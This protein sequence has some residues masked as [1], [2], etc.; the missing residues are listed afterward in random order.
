MAHGRSA[1]RGGGDPWRGGRR[2][3][4]PAFAAIDLGTNNCRL[5]IAEPAREGF[6]VVS[7]YS[8]IVR[9]GEGLAATGRLSDAAMER[10]MAALCACAERL[11]ARPV[12]ASRCMATQA[13]R[14]A[15]N[16]L[17]FLARVERELGL[18]FAIIE[19]EEEARL[20]VL[21]CASL[22][23]PAVEAAL[24]VDI[25]GGSTELSWVEPS[26]AG[27]TMIR[28]WASL[29]IGVV[30]LAERW[31]EPTPDAADGV[32]RPGWFDSMKRDAADAMDTAFADAAALAHLMRMRKAHIIGTS[33]AVTSLAGVH[34]ELER[35][36]R[37]LIDGVWLGANECAAATRR[38]F[39][40]ALGDRA[41]HPCIGPARADLVLAGCA[42]LEAVLDRWPSDRVRVADRGLREGALIT[43][44]AA[45]QAGRA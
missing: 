16:G 37:S 15:A 32:Q 25:G 36:R 20:A 13:C 19:P 18:A 41:R 23:D 24:I 33:G 22:I 7:G 42:I 30:T 5:L 21:G 43:L 17:E 11:A 14:A 44:I 28:A 3:R 8:Q 39:E 45:H 2:P 34:L 12:T 4:Q 29:P 40:M 1:K 6:R 31:P 9:L 26:G 35:Y 10:T 27:A 38:L